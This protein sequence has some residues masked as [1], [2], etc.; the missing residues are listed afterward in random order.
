VRVGSDTSADLVILENYIV[1]ILY[2]LKQQHGY[3]MNK[4]DFNS[5]RIRCHDQFPPSQH[6]FHIADCHSSVG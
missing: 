2:I 3:C 4:Q 5:N 1:N 6:R